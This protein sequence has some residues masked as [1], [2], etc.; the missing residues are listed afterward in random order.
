MGALRT[1]NPIVDMTL[2]VLVCRGRAYPYAAQK[3]KTARP[4]ASSQASSSYV[5]FAEA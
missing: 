4:A 3:A 5:R 2:A 1:G